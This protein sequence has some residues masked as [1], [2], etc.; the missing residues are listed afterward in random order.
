MKAAMKASVMNVEENMMWFK[1]RVVGAIQSWCVTI[2][3]GFYP[4]LG[5][6][7]Q[8]CDNCS[9]SLRAVQTGIFFCCHYVA[10]YRQYFHQDLNWRN[11]WGA[12]HLCSLVFSPKQNDVVLIHILLP[13]LISKVQRTAYQDL[14]QG[15]F[16]GLWPLFIESPC[17]NKQLWSWCFSFIVL[18]SQLQKSSSPGLEPTTDFCGCCTCLCNLTAKT[19]GFGLGAVR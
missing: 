2:S 3:T 12:C 8:G 9:C 6:I 17:C 16:S 5:H 10:K 19:N 14:N 11:F 13:S 15:S 1:I 4:F 7:F 18:V